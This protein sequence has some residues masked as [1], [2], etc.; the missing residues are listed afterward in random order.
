MPYWFEKTLLAMDLETTGLD[1]IEDRI[2][3]AAVVLVAG[4]GTVSDQSWDSI[5]DP[6]VP[7]PVDAS[8]IHGITIERARQEGMPPLEALRRMARFIDDAAEGG[9]PMVIFNAPFD[10]PFVLA[11][12]QRHGVSIAKPVIVAA[13]VIDRAVD[14]YRRGSRRL[15]AVA[16]HYG[17]DPGQAHDARTD[18]IAAAA[19]ARALGARYSEVGDLTPRALQPRQAQWHAAHADSLSRH[20]GK[21]IDSGWPL[22]RSA[23]HLG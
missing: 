20:L 23:G 4:D 9:V 14:R 5:V 17:Q 13:L 12:G 1:P 21:P 18:A 10:W 11:E 6:G 16:A 19:I 7:I 8:N 2:V 3:Q 15:D 22:P